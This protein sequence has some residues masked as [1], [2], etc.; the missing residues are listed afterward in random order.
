MAAGYNINL[1]SGLIA[2]GPTQLELVVID[3]LP[4]LARLSGERGRALHEWGLG[5]QPG[6]FRR[7][8]GHPDRA[9]VYMSDQSHTAFFRAAI[10]AGIRRECVRS[11]PSDERFR[12]DLEALRRTVAKDQATGFN[13]VAICA[14]AG[15]SSNGA[16]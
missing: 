11:I 12:L 3:W 4:A 6:R 13:P 1:A 8:A 16:T 14:N 7:G 15:A 10:I 2:R 5:G 9:T